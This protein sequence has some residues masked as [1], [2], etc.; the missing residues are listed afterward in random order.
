MHILTLQPVWS[1]SVHMLHCLL[2]LLFW[3]TTHAGTTAQPTPLPL[4]LLPPSLQVL[5]ELQ[6]GN[7]NTAPILKADALKFTTTFR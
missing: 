2:K 7:V 1:T 4:S 6:E 3:H 5:P